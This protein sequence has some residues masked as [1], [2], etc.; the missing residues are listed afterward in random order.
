MLQLKFKRDSLIKI[1]PVQSTELRPH[2]CAQVR[3]DEVVNINWAFPSYDGHLY[4]S[5]KAPLNGKH[6]NHIFMKDAQIIRDER[7]DLDTNEIIAIAQE[8]DVEPALLIALAETESAGNGFLGDGRPCILFERHIFSDLTGG[9]YDDKPAISSP[10]SGGYRSYAREWEKLQMALKLDQEAALKSA[11]WGLGQLLGENYENCG[12]KSVKDMIVQ[13]FV[14]EA[15]QFRATIEFMQA[16]GILR[17][18]RQK[19]WAAFARRY[20]GPNYDRGDMDPT[21]DYDYKLRTNY[22]SVVNQYA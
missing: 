17:L 9:Q 15:E 7:H 16:E 13:M 11:S 3:K 1:K 6:N 8:L 5:L 12:Y 18:L 20:N 14:S 2:Q 4:V 21:N 10:K 19:R 22:Q